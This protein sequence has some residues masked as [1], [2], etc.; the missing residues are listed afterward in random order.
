MNPTDVSLKLALAKELPELI[1]I[2]E[3]YKVCETLRTLFVWLDTDKEVTERE[4]DWVVTK[5]WQTWKENTPNYPGVGAYLV[6]SSRVCA[7][8]TWQERAKVYFK[9]KGIVT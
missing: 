3:T 1:K 4:W 2:L 5:L 7:F 9:V 8:D 6:F